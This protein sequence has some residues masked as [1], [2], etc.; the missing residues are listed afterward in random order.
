MTLFTCARDS[1]HR[2]VVRCAPADGGEG[3]AYASTAIG[4]PVIL[5]RSIAVRVLLEIV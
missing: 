4:K 2:V 5:S 1:R 3:N